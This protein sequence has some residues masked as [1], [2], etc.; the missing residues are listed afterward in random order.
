MF[1]MTLS[2]PGLKKL[3]TL[4][5]CG[6]MLAGV[7]AGVGR[8]MERDSVSA[9]ARPA[10]ETIGSTQDIIRYFSQR[11]L[12]LDLTTAAVDQVK[13]PR[14]WDDSFSAFNE[15]V[16]Q[17]GLD[18]EKY[19]GKKVEKWTALCPG[20]SQGDQTLYG[21]LLVYKQKPV[22]AYLLSRPGGE[23]TALQPAA[24]TAAPLTEE[25]LAAAAGFGVQEVQETA[26]PPEEDA[27]Q[28]AVLAAAGAE[29]VE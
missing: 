18:L 5:V 20:R 27:E 25:E 8:W 22:G 26:V 19:R 13:I 16:K 9:S 24:Q 4:A 10:E 21:V 1:M 2:K 17:S 23:V 29:P 3:G 6:L 14:K 15:V 7:V 11:G 28:E 12:E